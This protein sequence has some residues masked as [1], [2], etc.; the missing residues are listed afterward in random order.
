[1]LGATTDGGITWNFQPFYFNQNEGRGID[2]FFFDQSTGLVSGF[3]W[4]G[5]GAIARTTD[6]GMN[7]PTSFFAQPIEAIDFPQASSGFSV[8]LGGRILHSTDAGIAWTDQTSGTSANLND[9]GFAGDGLTGITVGD[10]GTILRTTNGGEP[11]PTVTV[12]PTPT[13][14]ATP[15]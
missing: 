4:D 12:T 3:R 2:V 7:W 15:M 9:V 6:G 11:A 10:S 14:T 5:P 13:A 8:G 1:M